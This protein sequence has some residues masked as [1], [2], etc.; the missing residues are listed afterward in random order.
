ML[1]SS[2]SFRTVALS[3]SFALA[4]VVV[5]T[6]ASAHDHESR[7]RAMIWSGNPGGFEF[8]QGRHGGTWL[9]VQLAPLTPELR[10]HFGVPSEAG[11]MISKVMDESPAFR[12][13]L[14]VGD[15]ITALDGEPVASSG[16]LARSIGGREDGETVILEVWRNGGL[17][18]VSAVVEDRVGISGHHSGVRLY[19]C[20]EGGDCDFQIQ[21][22]GAVSEDCRGEDPCK[23]EM[24]CSE[25]ECACT[26]NDIEVD[27]EGLTDVHG[28]D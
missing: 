26:A 12:A 15:I 17:E 9:G 21:L 7:S 14:Q 4:I 6:P 1:P 23:V 28:H 24:T 19:E 16:S 18:Q 25:G 13:G 11:V 2:R 10:I 20:A 8:H 5:T 3:L 22:M 27:C